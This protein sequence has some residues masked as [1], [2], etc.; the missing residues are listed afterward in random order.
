MM[1]INI[2]PLKPEYWEQ[3]KQI[4]R[5][6]IGTGNAT[7]E[8]N[9]TEWQTWDES[10]LP[11]S[12]L[13][14]VENGEVCG[15]AALT[16]VSGRCVYAG[17]AEVSVYVGERHRGK[18]IGYM[19]L[20]QL[21]ISSEANHIWTVQ[22]GIFRENEASIGLHQKLG[23]RI[24]GYKEKVGKMNGAWRDVMQ[25]ERRSKIVGI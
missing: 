20:E 25:L 8:T 4:Y 2:E 21:I 12:R 5:D 14:A 7:F 3:V 9:A 6:G 11:H 1:T 19:L 23:F 13:V 18:G 16:P 24:V 15:W 22:A 17:V 10:H